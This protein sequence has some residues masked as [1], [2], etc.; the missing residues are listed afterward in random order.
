MKNSENPGGNLRPQDKDSRRLQELSL[1]NDKCFGE[2]HSDIHLDM[3]QDYT[4]SRIFQEKSL[5]EPET[6]HRL[7]ELEGTQ[8][9]QSLALAVLK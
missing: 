6:L 4:I 9:L 7:C 3:K 5:S 8:I 2:I 1:I